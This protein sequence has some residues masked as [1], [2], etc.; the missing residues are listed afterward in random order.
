MNPD[1]SHSDRN[2]RT[3]AQRD[4]TASASEASPSGDARVDLQLL[5]FEADRAL[6][7]R[8]TA[9]ARAWL[10]DYQTPDLR[11]G[12][13]QDGAARG[14]MARLE[15]A[16]SLC[17]PAP[18]SDAQPADDADYESAPIIGKDLRRRREILVASAGTRIRFSRK[19]GIHII[20]RERDV[21]VETCVWFD[22]HPDVGCLDEF[23]PQPDIKARV[24]SPAFLKPTA[25]VQ[26]KALDH[27]RLEGRL[28][29]G[30]AG[31]PCILDLTGAKNEPGVRIRVRIE[32][33][34][35]NHRLRIRFRGLA[36]TDLLTARGTPG[37]R[38]VEHRSGGFRTATLLR[39][40][41]KLRV[42]E[43][44]IETPGA[45]SIGWIEHT[46]GLGTQA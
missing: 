3:L 35:R 11:A 7:T 23:V 39:A 41:G 30:S 43:R 14:M 32:N 46:F 31:F 6:A 10:A 34:H 17:K 22:D 26:S 18:D 38:D 12:T 20:D 27:L 42:D 36:Q 21:N 4:P 28:G 29:R 33:R 16:I 44:W 37:M 19:G 25:L 13:I 8:G 15:E 45:Q 2:A 40:C 9:A 24:F 1:P 5:W